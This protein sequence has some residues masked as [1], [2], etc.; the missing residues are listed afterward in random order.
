MDCA[1]V[2]KNGTGHMTRNELGVVMIDA[3]FIKMEAARRVKIFLCIG[4]GLVRRE[5]SVISKTKTALF[6]RDASILAIPIGSGQTWTSGVLNCYL[7]HVYNKDFGGVYCQG[8]D[9]G[10]RAGVKFSSVASWRNMGESVDL[11]SLN[12]ESDVSFV[13]GGHPIYSNVPFIKVGTMM[14]VFVTR[15]LLNAIYA[16]TKKY[17][18]AKYNDERYV[19]DCSEYDLDK[20]RRVMREK[21][22]GR[23]FRF[24]NEWGLFFRNSGSSNSFFFKFEDLK[25]DPEKGFRKILSI[26]LREHEVDEDFLVKS[27]GQADLSTA[28]KNYSRLNGK[29][30]TFN[31]GNK[32]AV[33]YEREMS[34]CI[35]NMILEEIERGLL[36]PEAYPYSLY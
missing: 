29:Q 7:N 3:K 10:K 13:F 33:S 11:K 15:S 21:V 6:C 9:T 17:Y 8:Y 26:L 5:K 4:R 31:V 28:K 23:Y 30:D 12:S 27:V 32:G 25:S 16:K 19:Q 2:Q 36:Y 34:D 35:K 14:K 1:F 22:A 20:F 18:S 24:Y